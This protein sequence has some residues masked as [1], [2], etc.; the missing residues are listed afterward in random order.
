LDDIFHDVFDIEKAG[1]STFFV[2][3]GDMTITSMAH[4][5]ESVGDGIVGRETFGGGGHYGFD[6]GLREV[7]RRFLQ[8]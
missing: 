4:F 3:E 2:D 7:E 1:G 8:L 6:E 5:M